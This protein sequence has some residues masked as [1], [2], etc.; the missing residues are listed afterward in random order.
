MEDHSCLQYFTERKKENLTSP[1]AILPSSSNG[2][3]GRQSDSSLYADL[4]SINIQ[5]TCLDF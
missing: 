2:L 4:L 3:K 1:Y 5:N